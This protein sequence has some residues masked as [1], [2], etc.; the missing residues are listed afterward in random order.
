[1]YTEKRIG[2]LIK[3][4]SMT[5]STHTVKADQSKQQSKTLP[6]WMIIDVK[7]LLADRSAFNTL[8]TFK[9]KSRSKL[10]RADPILLALFSITSR[11]RLGPAV[12]S[13]P[14]R[15]LGGNVTLRSVP[16]SSAESYQPVWCE[17]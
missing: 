16:L 7:F 6:L 10:E 1:V 13:S 9:A 2:R 5:T 12:L 15:I 14:D 3:E 8:L 11:F 4:R 17:G